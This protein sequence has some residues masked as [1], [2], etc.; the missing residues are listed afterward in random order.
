MAKNC[1][2]RPHFKTHQ[3]KAIGIR[4]F[5]DHLGIE[6]ITVSSPQMAEY[7]AKSG[8][9]DITIAFPV[10]V[11]EIDL[12]N[13]LAKKIKLNLLLD[14]EE[15]LDFLIEHIENEVGIFIDIDLG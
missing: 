13:Q 4:V 5:K 8:F 6:Q 9:K 12:I 11:L 2:L 3:S 1:I 14:N 15:S 7:F 10:N